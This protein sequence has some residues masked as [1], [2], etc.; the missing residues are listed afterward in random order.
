M[1]YNRPPQLTITN[2]ERKKEKKETTNNQ[3][4][5]NLPCRDVNKRLSNHIIILFGVSGGTC[6]PFHKFE[7]LHEKCMI[8]STYIWTGRKDNILPAKA[9]L[10]SIFCKHLFRYEFAI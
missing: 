7:T 9:L 10:L 2:M 5:S 3:I 1:T 6:L 4:I 8:F